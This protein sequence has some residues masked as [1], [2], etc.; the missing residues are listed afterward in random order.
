MNGHTLVSQDGKVV[1]LKNPL[2]SNWIYQYLLN[3]A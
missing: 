2:K 1:I 3:W